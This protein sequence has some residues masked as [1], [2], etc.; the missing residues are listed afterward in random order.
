MFL[1]GKNIEFNI[2]ILIIF[3]D[4]VELFVFVLFVEVKVLFGLIFIFNNLVLFID[5]KDL[6]NILLV[7]MFWKMGFCSF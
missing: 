6:K 2:C 3:V 7:L 1:F 5:K 4:G